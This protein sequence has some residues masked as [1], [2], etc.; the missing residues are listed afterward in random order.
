[1]CFYFSGSLLSDLSYS[2]CEDD[3]DLTETNCGKIWKKHRPSLP[4]PGNANSTNKRHSLAS[5]QTNILNSLV[6]KGN[7]SWN[8]SSPSG[9]DEEYCILGCD[10][11]SSEFVFA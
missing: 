11:E 4:T 3:L 8:R 7:V 6:E 1:M 10:A 2:R 5:V 9:D